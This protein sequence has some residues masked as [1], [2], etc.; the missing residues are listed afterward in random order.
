MDLTTLPRYQC[1][2]VVRAAQIVWIEPAER[3]TLDE[4]EKILNETTEHVVEIASDGSVSVA[5]DKAA[6]LVFEGHPKRSLAVDSAYMQ[7]HKP[8]LGGYFVVYDDGYT[9]FSP[10]EA[11]EAGYTLLPE[12]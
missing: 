2:K 8:R 3:P 6:T 4:L 5:G 1:H 7:K 10:A 12:A 9:S 11:F